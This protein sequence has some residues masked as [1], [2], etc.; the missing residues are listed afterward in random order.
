MRVIE[1]SLTESINAMHILHHVGSI[2]H[3]VTLNNT[4]CKQ[5]K[6]IV[7]FLNAI[8]G[9]ILRIIEEICARI[10]TF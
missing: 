8:Y 5:F 9:T 6:A 1:C 3:E 10:I 2:T 4:Q 7:E